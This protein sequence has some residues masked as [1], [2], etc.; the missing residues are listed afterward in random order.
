MIGPKVK[1][2]TT[3]ADERRGR[4]AVKERD[5]GRCVRCCRVFPALNH[6]HR[7]NRSQGGDWSPANGQSL[8]G[9]G[10]TGCHGWVTSHPKKACDA[11]YAVPG[12]A[13][14]KEYPARRWVPTGYGTYVAVWVLY[15]DAPDGSGAWWRVIGDHEA[16]DR[17]DG[18]VKEGV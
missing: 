14:P 15:F 3:P 2:W 8:C 6:D 1:K 17:L 13:D 7:K 12:W 9:S 10:T 4:D 5:G 18:F 11:G 16:N